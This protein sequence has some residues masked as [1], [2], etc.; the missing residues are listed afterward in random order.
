MN[1]LYICQYYIAFQPKFSFVDVPYAVVF[2]LKLHI[3]NNRTIYEYLNNEVY[4]Y[5]H[6]N[7]VLVRT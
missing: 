4:K 1:N 5:N 6:M 3:F 7:L 2:L